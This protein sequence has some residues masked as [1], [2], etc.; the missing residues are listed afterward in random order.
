LFGAFAKVYD[1]A[2]GV[3][4]YVRVSNILN[5]QYLTPSTY[6]AKVAGVIPDDIHNRGF[7]IQV[8]LTYS[9]R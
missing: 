1:I 7:E 3:A 6:P 4:G 9:F 2:E 8:G 5:A